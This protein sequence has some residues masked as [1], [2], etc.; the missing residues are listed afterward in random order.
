MPAYID[1]I[2]DRMGL[3]DAN[4]A[5]SPMNTSVKLEPRPEGEDAPYYPYNRAIGQLMWLAVTCRPDIAFSV[6]LLATFSHNFDTA[7][8]TAVKRVYR[9]LKATIELGLTYNRNHKPFMEVGYV[10]SDFASQADRRSI[11]GNVFMFGGAAVS[12]TSKRQNDIATSTSQAE[13]TSC[14]TGSSQA[15][16]LRMFLGELGCRTTAPTHIF[17]DNAA[18]I[19]L[20][21]DPAHLT[22]TKHID[23][24]LLFI[25]E[26]V[27][28]RHIAIVQIPTEDNLA[29]AF[30]KPLQHTRFWY[31]IDSIMG[32][33]RRGF[34]HVYQP[35]DSQYYIVE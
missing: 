28:R 9:W 11:S 34:A 4:T 25:R 7:Q 26:K 15:E 30:T 33:N 6:N 16:W 1:R 14:Y 31:L 18:A 29:D 20:A 2:I 32:L 23:V 35:E 3:R 5:V 21:T 12:W 22:R 10:D 24:R 8:I 27:T 17:C 19:K 13:F